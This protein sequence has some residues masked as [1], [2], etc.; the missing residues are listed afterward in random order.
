MYAIRSYYAPDAPADSDPAWTPP[1][2]DLP[3][4]LCARIAGFSLHAARSVETHDRPGLER[5][6]RYGLRPPF[7]A[8]RLSVLPDGR[9]AYALRRPWTTRDGRSTRELVLD[10]IDFM[11]RLVV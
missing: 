7:A 4:P 8:E 10:P 5:L 11:R 9:V 2:D 1:P 3:P 6:C